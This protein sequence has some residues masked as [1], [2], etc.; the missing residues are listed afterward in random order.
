[1]T[2]AFNL[3]QLANKV[4]TSGQLDVS[5]G[6]T[7][8]QAVANGGTGQTTYTDGQLLIGNSTGNTLAKSTLTA[9][10]GISVTNGSGAITIANTLTAGFTNMQVFASPGT[11]TTPATTTQIKV[12]VVGGGGSGGTSP[13]PAANIRSGGGAGG[14]AIYV[15]PVSSS[16]PYAVTVGSGGNPG[17]GGTSSFGALASSTGGSTGAASATPVSGGSGGAGSAGTLLLTGNTAP[18][19]AAGNGIGGASILGGAGSTAVKGSGGNGN[20]AAGGTGLVIV[21]Y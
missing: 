8:T 18:T 5:T 12:T 13:S 11:F 21:E 19:S 7:G 1:M 15:G 16:T 3:S 20:N 9:G 10:T 14:A 6:V 4:N 17:S 2:Q